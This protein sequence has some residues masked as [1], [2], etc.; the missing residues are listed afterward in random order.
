MYSGPGAARSHD[1]TPGPPLPERRADLPS[2]GGARGGCSLASKRR[3]YDQLHQQAR[4][5]V[6]ELG[7]EHAAALAVARAAA[8]EDLLAIQ[9]T[10]R[11]IQR[12]FEKDRK[13]LTAIRAEELHPRP[14]LGV[15]YD[16]CQV[17]IGNLEDRLKRQ[18]FS[19]KREFTAATNHTKMIRHALTVRLQELDRPDQDEEEVREQ[20]KRLFYFTSEFPGGISAESIVERERILARQLIKRASDLLIRLETL[21]PTVPDVGYE[22]NP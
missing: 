18:T 11:A 2:R 16:R 19:T 8:G 22:D 3:E 4:A 17:M 7:S 13:R 6:P 14:G 20:V 21:A 15:L 9:S 1:R 5:L 10:V 12:R